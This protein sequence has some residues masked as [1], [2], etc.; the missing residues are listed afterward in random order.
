[1]NQEDL[2]GLLRGLSMEA[3]WMALCFAAVIAE[4]GPT[5]G[6]TVEGLDR[7]VSELHE[8]EESFQALATLVEP[9]TPNLAESSETPF[10]TRLRLT[11]RLVNSI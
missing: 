6:A 11:P 9:V 3:H 4:S 8:A 2:F 5:E 7:I 10:V 1:M